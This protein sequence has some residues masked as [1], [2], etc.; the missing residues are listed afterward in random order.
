MAPVEERQYR[1]RGYKEYAKEKP[2]QREQ[3]PVSRTPGMPGTRSVARCAECGTLLPAPTDSL[4]HCPK[5]RTALHACRQCAHFD[6]GRRFECAEP[7]PERIPDKRARNECAFF[8]LRVTLERDTRAGS[9]RPED[10]RRAFDNLFK[11]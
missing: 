2:G 10:A 3:P 11:K 8:A 4:A 1:Q 7:I 6:P 5:C 9:M